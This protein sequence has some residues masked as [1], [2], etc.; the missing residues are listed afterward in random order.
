MMFRQAPRMT[1]AIMAMLLPG[2]GQGAAASST[3]LTIEV[4]EAL[5]RHGGVVTVYPIPVSPEEWSADA[6]P[7]APRVRVGSR[8]AEVQLKYPKGGDYVFRF[9]RIAGTPDENELR[10]QLLSVIG[11]DPEG[12]GPQMTSGFV[13]AYSSSGQIIRVLPLGEY[14]GTDEATRTNARWGKTVGDD[15]ASPADEG[16]ARILAAMVRE[17]MKPV[18]LE[19]KIDRQVQVCSIPEGQWP[20]LE[21]RWW[22]Y[23]AEA[24]LERLDH[25]ALRRCYDSTWFGGGACIAD[26]KSDE[27]KYFHR[28]AP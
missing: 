17:G 14:A 26:P 5:L 16:G 7:A 2:V 19:C 1:V 3:T 25:Y 18:P 22:R 12:R 24:R 21:A 4:S 9:R 15:A 6:G 13:N 27:P 20:A 11:T 8:Y 28:T 23:I 10:T